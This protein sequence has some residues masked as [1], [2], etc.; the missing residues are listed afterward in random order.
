ML[1]FIPFTL[2]RKEQLK[3]IFIDNF[4][5][6][7]ALILSVLASDLERENTFFHITVSLINMAKNFKNIAPR[8]TIKNFAPLF[9]N[10]TVPN[11]I[12]C[13]SGKEAKRFACSISL[14]NRSV[15]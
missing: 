8:D 13:Y 12:P 2:L 3:S 14:S 15:N 5:F 1:A 6:L 4:F 7:F 9:L 10:I 11:Q